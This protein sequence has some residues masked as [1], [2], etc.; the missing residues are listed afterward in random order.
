MQFSIKNET[1]RENVIILPANIH[2]IAEAVP[3]HSNVFGLFEVNR[4]KNNITIPHDEV[5]I[6][7]MT[8]LLSTLRMSENFVSISANIHILNILMFKSI[9]FLTLVYT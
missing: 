4:Y 8:K 2:A 7:V 3:V 9:T 5:A 1:A 6:P